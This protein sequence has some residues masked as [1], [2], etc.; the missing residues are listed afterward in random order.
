MAKYSIS[1][2]TLLALS[3]L[4]SM[5]TLAC[6]G[7][8]DEGSPDGEMSQREAM[9]AR[10]IE[11]EFDTEYVPPPGDALVHHASGFAKI[12][13]SGVFITG[14]DADF[15]A[16]NIGYFTAAYDQRANVVDRVIDWDNKA[17]H[18]T[19]PAHQALRGQLGTLSFGNSKH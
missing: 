7:S 18:L 1:R 17:V 12:L 8:S 9:L 14:L 19:L 4:F 15:V 16:E 13:C 11:L 5:F 6:Q 10:A 3:V 2:G